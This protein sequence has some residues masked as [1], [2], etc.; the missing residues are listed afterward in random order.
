MAATPLRDR[1]GLRFSTHAGVLRGSAT[2]GGFGHLVVLKGEE[3]RSEKLVKLSADVI[4]G[5]TA[6][7]QMVDHE[8]TE[9][10]EESDRGMTAN[11]GV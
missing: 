3:A 11:W 2:L 1:G 7:P 10:T 5:G 8:L 6:H 4:D 9:G